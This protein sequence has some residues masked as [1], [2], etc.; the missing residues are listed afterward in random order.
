MKGGI[1][2]G[3][4]YPK[5]ITE[6]ATEFNFKN[7]GGT[8]AGAIAAA[9]T[10]AAEYGRRSGRESSFGIVSRLPEELGAD[11]LLLRLFQPSAATQRTFHVALT[12]IS[13]GRSTAGKLF[14]VA[15]CLLRTYFPSALFGVVLGSIFPAL[16]FYIFQGHWLPYA[17]LGLL[18]I[19]FFS[20]VVVLI[21]AFREGLRGMVGNGFGLVSG[22]DPKAK[23]GPPLTNWLHRQIQEAA[24]R[25]GTDSPLTFGDLWHAP[26]YEDE[27]LKTDRTINLEVVTSNLTQG[28]PYDIPFETNIF[29][30]DE[31]EFRRLFPAE[32]VEWLLSHPRPSGDQ[33]PVVS[34]DG[35]ALR[36]LPLPENMPILV[37][38]R[39][40][41]SFPILLSAVPLYAVDFTF[42]INQTDAKQLTAERCW[43]SDGGISSNFPIHFFDSPLPRWPTF[44]I[45]LKAP[46]P[47]HADE[48]DMVFLPPPARPGTQIVWNQIDGGSSQFNEVINFFGAIINTMQNWRDNLQASAPDYRDR[49]V[50]IS[51]R[52]NEGGLNLT[53]PPQLLEKLTKRGEEA[54]TL[55]V[56]NFDFTTHMWARFRIGMCA[57]QKYLMKLQESWLKPV[58][59]EEGGR[60][61]IE[62]RQDPLHYAC[63]PEMRQL[64]NKALHD[65]LST[66]AEWQ[67]LLST[68]TF[69]GDG[70][71]RPEPI[72]RTE[73]KF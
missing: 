60:L 35:K 49:I 21:T 10:A 9:L 14:A 41:L 61:V 68:Q 29:F 56:N 1:T 73:P 8:S 69:C 52:D 43:F 15:L 24:G 19:A 23:S 45:T 31:D 47:E 62:G 32:I 65:L 59:Q 5:A 50:Q 13:S 46:H 12:A 53:M 67:A 3:I 51:L 27:T 26:L 7:I 30:F 48:K 55:L 11:N 20:I 66:S 18:W 22:F 33:R 72:L 38:A 42:K 25:N 39:M 34:R 16:L 36:R 6:L 40:S 70:S 54:G 2:S 57:V 17:I 28:R 4:V 63:T 44:G 58:A 37:A 64:L 71:P